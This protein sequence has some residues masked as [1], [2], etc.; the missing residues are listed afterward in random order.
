M[1]VRPG[2]PYPVGATWDGEGV[3]FALFTAHATRVELCL[4]EGDEER[5]R[6]V[7]PEQDDLVWH[8]RLPEVRPGQAYGYRVHGPYAPGEG[9]RFNPAKLLIDPYAKAITRPVQW[10]DALFGYVPGDPAADLSLN[11]ADSAAGLPKCVVIEPAF[12]WGDD[13]PPRIPWHRTF[14]Y[15]CHVKGLTRRHPDVPERLRGTYLGLASA[16]IIDHL[17]ALGVTAV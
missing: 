16:P 17:R 14:I 10:S 6:I 5:E 13:R 9:H 2:S 7:L 1:R 15:E 11:S 4:F 12:T 3:N 8:A